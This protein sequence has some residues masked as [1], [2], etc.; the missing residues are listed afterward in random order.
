MR[1]RAMKLQDKARVQC[2]TAETEV[3]NLEDQLSKQLV[4]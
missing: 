1:N 3:S 4:Y 2:I